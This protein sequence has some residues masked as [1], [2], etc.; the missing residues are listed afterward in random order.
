MQRT[1]PVFDTT[2]RDGEQAAGVC[3]SAS[4]KLEIAERL[5][6]LRVDVIEAGFPISSPEECAAVAGVAANVRG[7]R[8][9][10]S[11]ARC[12]GTSPPPARRC[13]APE[14]PHPRFVTPATCSSRTSSGRCA[15]RWPRWPRPWCGARA[16]HRRH[17]VQ[18]DGR[19]A[20][21]PGVPGRA[22][23][24]V[25]AAGAGTIN[26][27]DTVGSALPEQVAG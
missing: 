18:P 1:D 21:R 24:A 8:S 13:A 17:R 16:V 22:V 20:R 10:R 14:P 5:A 23:R 12:P 3:F 4:D 9:A 15:R 25:L 2:L 26:L 19:D 11:R 27:P 7:A 6:A